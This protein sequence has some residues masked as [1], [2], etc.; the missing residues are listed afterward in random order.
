MSQASDINGDE[1]ADHLHAG[2]RRCNALAPG[3]DVAVDA[4]AA[5]AAVGRVGRVRTSK[6]DRELAILQQPCQCVPVPLRIMQP[7]DHVVHPSMQH[8]QCHC[9]LAHVT[10]ACAVLMYIAEDD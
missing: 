9:I 6:A 5:G 1:A 10:W 7:R 8:F 4:A 2:Q 3:R